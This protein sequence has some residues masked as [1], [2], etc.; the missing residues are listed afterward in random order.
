[1]LP[2]LKV[3][4]FAIALSVATVSAAPISWQSAADTTDPSVVLTSGVLLEAA[5]ASQTS[6]TVTIN[7]V[8]FTPDDS[9]LPN[10]AA[11]VALSGQET[12]DPG[13]DAMLNSV[14][15]GGGTSVS[16]GV[17]G[18]ALVIGQSYLIQV[19]YTD[20]RSGRVMTFGDG[21]GS[22]VDLDSQGSAGA[23]GQYAIGSFV[24]DGSNQTL[25]IVAPTANYVH[26]NGYQIRT[27][28]PPLVIS[29]FTESPALITSGESS[30]LSWQISGVGSAEISPEVGS[31][32]ATSGNVSVSPTVTTTYTLTATNSGGSV[33]SE[34][35]IGVDLTQIEPVISEFLASN[36]SGL[37]DENGADS[38]WIEIHNPN[39]FAIDLG[40]YHL[41]DD[42]SNSSKWTF[43]IGTRI[44]G[45]GYLIVFASGISSASDP[46]H[47]NFRISAMSN[48][49]GLIAPG[50]GA[51][52][53]DY[54]LYPN[55]ETNLSYGKSGGGIGY[56]KPPTPGAPNG[57]AYTGSV[58]DTSFDVDRGFFDAPFTVN[59]SS[60]TLGSTI[61]YTTD[62]TDPTL[63][64]G[65]VVPPVD[66]STSG[67]A[68][69]LISGTTVLRAAAFKEN[70]IPT[71]I[72]TQTYLFIAD[73]LSQPEMDADVVNDPAYSAEMVSALQSIR[74][75]SIVTDPDN[76]FD[77]TIGIL[78]NTQG[79][80]DEWERPVSVEFIDPDDSA[81]SFQ[82]DAGVRMH[83][84]GSRGGAKNSLRLLFRSDY[85][86]K[87]LVYPLFGTD[88]VTA[89]FNTV[90]LRAQG[91]NAWTAGRSLD[92]T[93]ATYLQDTFAKDTQ[94]AM[95]HPTA[96]STFVH[97]FLNG[98]YWGL[99]N[100]TERPDG[101]F[102]EDHFGGDDTD[103]DA[104]NRRFSVEVL[105]GTK[106]NWDAMIAHA[107]TLLDTQQE[108]DQIQSFIYIDNLIDYMLIHQYMQT[109]DGP[110]DFGHN[111]M[112]LI[113]RNNPPEPWRAYVWDMEYSMLDTTGTRNYSYPFPI[114]SSSR[115]SNRD[116]SDSI[117]ALYLR[118]KDN[119]PEFQLRYADRAYKHLYHDGALSVPAATA[120][121][122][123]R[124]EEI[125][126]AVLG[127]S[128]RWGDHQRAVPY[129]RDVEWAAERN[130]LLNEFFPARPNHVV[131]QLRIHGLYPG[132]DPPAL[133]QHGGVVEVGYELAITAAEGEI[134]YTTDGSDPRMQ[135][136]AISPS[137]T[138]YAGP[139]ELENIET[140][141]KAR[142][143]VSGTGE[144]SAV[145]DATFE[146]SIIPVLINEILTHTD[147]PEVDA[148]ELY[149]PNSFPADIGGWFLTD[150]ENAPQSFRIPDGTTIPA[151]GYL[152][153]DES[154]FAVGPNAFRLSEYG[155][156][157][158]LLSANTS[159]VLTG[160][161][162][163]WNF[164]AAPNGVT[165]G[166]H[167]DSQGKA[168][169]VLQAA[170]TLGAENSL[171]KV[172]PVIVSEIHYR[173]PNLDG[174]IG[175]SADEF[176]ELENISGSSVPLY[177]TDTSVPSYGNAAL[178]DTWRLRNAVAF[179]FPPGVELQVG[180]RVLVVGF[181]PLVD[182]AQLAS[183]RSKYD[184]PSGVR[185]FGPWSG[186]LNNSGEKI[187]WKFPGS[188]DPGL[189]YF[190]PYY[191]AEEID[192]RDA[193]PWPPTA[194][195]LG[196]SLQRI[197]FSEFANDP[198]NW[199]AD[200]PQA[201]ARR[202]TD[203]DQIE[204]W[205]E[206]LHGLTLG[207]DDSGLDP[208]LDN[209]TN[210][211]EFTARTLPFD[212]GSFLEMSFDFTEAGLLLQFTAKPGVGYA[213]Q[214]ADSLL[215]PISWSDWQQVSA[216]AQERELQFA[217]PAS[218]ERQFFRVVTPPENGNP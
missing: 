52:V 12:L 44:P 42:I 80:G 110:D 83:G 181:D 95:G 136:G 40:G 162:H 187:E 69:V 112:R 176:I 109:R 84:N 166:R 164:S 76:L 178:D 56:F 18:G 6:G 47:T 94:G 217:V 88:W 188:A 127:E 128:A 201:T 96:G 22:T 36:D 218:Q 73:I 155:E 55:Q 58:L 67:A 27:A 129:T 113:R 214:S 79:R 169:F 3:I 154:D 57:P 216:D 53:D 165:I 16:L 133:S 183:L 197:A 134:Y 210:L 158:Y 199:R 175:N 139:F 123:A 5:N 105:S 194:D 198:Q 98:T 34:L 126:S 82:T 87:N 202:D 41:T 215:P 168:H 157:A 11:N 120:R 189:A 66:G 28:V 26:I 185:V 125:K 63:S 209:R 182:T 174:G 17:G 156:Q 13:L 196:S 163:G 19:F 60:E 160:Y 1:M 74:S 186:K 33:T 2:V 135:G 49:L 64:N 108:Y 204:D 180:E 141:V 177:S 104:V 146:V 51:V 93:S 140:Q 50:G 46:L 85:G 9:L 38:D 62:G 124:A 179:D 207:V 70:L 14:D 99:Y 75:L 43:P 116:I 153:F 190:V 132:I 170:N 184:I 145:A 4:S 148:I 144:W 203:N 173:P 72:D 114:Y 151:G 167:V 30:T 161:S 159:G 212:P 211:H 171:P 35:T 25:S 7:G 92:R 193:A 115:S 45:D 23:F 130:R 59:I 117:A 21:M 111:N 65:I 81:Q 119:N 101:S 39:P 24:A 102:G 68:A 122:E 48:Y 90:V 206:I 86:A 172:G 118:L 205:W 97:L 208:D 89:K 54:N 107:E 152:V 147:L 103:Y 31:V 20:L 71:D 150:N 29:S 195:G 191:T 8:G 91:S 32:S 143:F 137:A 149:N 106:T 121:F 200:N 100:P 213:I 131:S 138:A 78:E 77:P 61:V 37:L 142:A 15:Y 10:S 192:Y